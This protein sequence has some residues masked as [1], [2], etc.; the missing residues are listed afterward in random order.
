MSSR[1]NRPHH[2]PGASG[3]PTP[4]APP[5]RARVR[6]FAW[7]LA[8]A[9]LCILLAAGV[10][11]SF[12]TSRP[13]PGPPPAPP[14]AASPDPL[15]AAAA[16]LL[17]DQTSTYAAYAGSATCKPCHEKAYAKW[18]ESNHALAERPLAPDDRPAFDPAR[19]FAHGTQTTHVALG[20]DGRPVITALGASGAP[21]T[22]QPQRIIGNDPLRQ[23]LVSFPG[24]RLQTL[25]ASYDPHKEEWF[26]VFGNED[27]RPGEWGHW[28]G[29]GMNWNSMCASCH[30]TRVRKNYDPATD[31]YR[32]AMAEPAVSCEACH[33]PMQDHVAWQQRHTPTTASTQSPPFGTRQSA[34]G[35][36]KDPTI[37]R[38]SKQQWFDTCG[39]CHARQAQLTGDFKPGDDYFDHYALIVVDASDLYHPDGQV[40]DEDFELAA[41]MGSRM[42]A[43][44]VRCNDC[45]DPHDAMP[46]LGGNAL[47]M[48][49]HS[50]PTKDFPTAPAIDAARHSFHKPGTPGSQCVDCHMPVTTYMQR[51]PRHDHGFTVPDPQLTKEL[52]IPN[53][54]NRCHT[55]KDVDWSIGHVATWYGPRMD[56]PNRQEQRARTRLIAAARRGDRSDATRDGLVRHL[57][58][59]KAAPYWQAVAAGLLDGFAGQPPA[60]EAL[61]A[62]LSNPSPLV[63]SIAARTLGAP[64]GGT[65][66][67]TLVALTRLLD[68]PLRSVRLSAAWTLRDRLPDPAVSLAHRE[69]L[70]SMAHNADQPTG[71]AQI[72]H[73]HLARRRGDVALAHLGKAVEWDARSA[74]LR[75][76]LAVLYAMLGRPEDSLRQMREAVAIEPNHADHRFHLGLALADLGRLADARAAFVAA[77][78]LDPNHARAWYNMGLASAQLGERERALAE[79]ARAE[80]IDPQ[81]PAIP[82]ARA[83]VL[84]Q[85]NRLPLARAAVDR[86]LSLDPA[87]PDAHRLRRALED[88]R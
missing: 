14:A 69:L 88:R 85:L 35:T 15:A 38:L 4:P 78:T 7:P 36:P 75:R 74:A 30:N 41:F 19:S 51:H 26:N 47:C 48:K 34:I 56:R 1:R 37:V 5:P 17:P 12:R 28:T 58:D 59:P 79:L 76:D 32:T 72:A 65:S 87:H 61:T 54:C 84:A 29:R 18:A 23:F 21:E 86:A 10:W 81:D 42:H 63:R 24:G 2:R 11:L 62:A 20:P 53:A 71:Q 68:D 67:A 16:S 9:G 6:S 45:H 83:T 44:G 8:A 64:G 13:A 60:T 46:V 50:A 77:T 70:A 52:G 25:E 39:S 80:A 57:R 40:R 55:D 33:G 66:P 27:R 82:Y 43:A 49:C 73:Y 31:A 22:H 3:K